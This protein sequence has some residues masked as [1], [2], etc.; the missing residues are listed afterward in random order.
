MLACRSSQDTSYDSYGTEEG[1]SQQRIYGTASACAVSEEA[2]EGLRHGSMRALHE[3][4]RCR[5][6]FNRSHLLLDIPGHPIG[7]AY[8]LWRQDLLP[9]LCTQ[10][11]PVAAA[12]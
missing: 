12:A 6:I 7:Q 2:R 8:L 4:S 3:C 11:Y 1:V 10:V 5:G 9:L